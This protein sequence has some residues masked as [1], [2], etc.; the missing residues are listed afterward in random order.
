MS[1]R[2]IR[3]RQVPDSYRNGK[4]SCV[5][6]PVVRLGDVGKWTMVRHA[7]YPSALP[8]VISRKDWDKL[9]AEQPEEAA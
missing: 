2:E 4:W 6:Q 7:D 8:F 1:A 9:P 5:S 3:Y